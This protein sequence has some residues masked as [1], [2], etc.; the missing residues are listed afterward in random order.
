M[1]LFRVQDTGGGAVYCFIFL[2]SIAHL[3]GAYGSLSCDLKNIEIA[4]G[5]VFI[6]NVQVAQDDAS[7]LFHTVNDIDTFDWNLFCPSFVRCDY[8]KTP[9]LQN[10]VLKTVFAPQ[11]DDQRATRPAKPKLRRM[12][13]KNRR[14]QLKVEN[15]ETNYIN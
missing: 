5:I 2:L 3:V 4:D 10:N 8:V 13:T 11:K 7:N 6:F 9:F 15:K 14:N 12:S 1:G